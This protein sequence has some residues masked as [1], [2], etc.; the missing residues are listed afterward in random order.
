MKQRLS[1]IFTF[2]FIVLL[3]IVF[4]NKQSFSYTLEINNVENIYKLSN[5][6]E[7]CDAVK[8][9]DIFTINIHNYRGYSDEEINEMLNNIGIDSLESIG[10]KKLDDYNYQIMTPNNVCYNASYREKFVSKVSKGMDYPPWVYI[11]RMTSYSVAYVDDVI[12]KKDGTLNGNY[13]FLRIINAKRKYGEESNKLTW[14]AT[15]KPTEKIYLSINLSK[16]NLTKTD[17]NND[18]RLSFSYGVKSGDINIGKYDSVAYYL[19]ANNTKYGPYKFEYVNLEKVY[20]EN[21]S[22]INIYNIISENL[23]KDI[24]KDTIINKIEIV[25]Y[26]FFG[27]LGGELKLYDLSIDKYQNNYIPNKE[28]LS[29]AANDLQ[30][31]T[32]AENLI[33]HRIIDDRMTQGLVK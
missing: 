4:T 30:N 8:E 23:F 6:E 24:P 33:R 22:K 10:I 1:I 12:V 17:N 31:Y 3:L 9:K 32:D 14:S 28:Y 5:P 16:I 2:I 18:L 15:R 25:P 21:S 11:G 27:L 20:Y 7:M 26:E 13:S 29:I 19:Y